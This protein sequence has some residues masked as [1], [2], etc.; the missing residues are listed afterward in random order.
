M[1]YP[2]PKGTADLEERTG[3]NAEDF[4]DLRSGYAWTKEDELEDE[5]QEEEE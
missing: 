5:D 1:E 3:H 2:R 4:L